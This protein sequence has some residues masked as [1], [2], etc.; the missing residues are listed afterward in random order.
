MHGSAILMLW[1]AHVR[2]KGSHTG[3]MFQHMHHQFHSA[4]IAE[5]CTALPLMPC[6]TRHCA[7]A[8][9]S[10]RTLTI[11]ASSGAGPSKAPCCC[12]Q[13]WP[14]AVHESTKTVTNVTSSISIARPKDTH[15]VTNTAQSVLEHSTLPSHRDPA[16]RC[17]DFMRW[18]STGVRACMYALL[19][20]VLL[21]A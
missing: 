14:D 21:C 2:N 12:P 10:L 13:R 8:P 7:R 20:L 4:L 3:D 17:C 5:L 15:E 18:A 16:K 1:V 9:S 11:G 6:G 19:Q